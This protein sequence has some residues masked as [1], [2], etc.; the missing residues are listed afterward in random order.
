VAVEKVAA[1][2]GGEKKD[3]KK[4]KGSGKKRQGGGKKEE[5]K[6]KGSKGGD[7]SKGGARSKNSV[8]SRNNSGGKGSNNSGGSSNDS[9]NNGGKG[10]NNSGGSSSGS[11]NSG[12]KGSNNSGGSSSNDSNNSGGKGSTNSGGSSSGSNNSSIGDEEETQKGEREKGNNTSGGSSG[13]DD[14]STGDDEET[15]AELDWGKVVKKLERRERS[16]AA[17][18][19]ANPTVV[20]FDA[21]ATKT[22]VKQATT[23]PVTPARVRESDKTA[24]VN[25]AVIGP[26]TV[27]QSFTH[28]ASDK[29]VLGTSVRVS[30]VSKYATTIKNRRG[31]ISI[32]GIIGKK[33]KKN[34]ENDGSRWERKLGRWEEVG[35]SSV[36]GVE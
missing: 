13:S 26:N 9:N 28:V 17:T 20:V 25:P 30:A 23:A 3:D 18:V 24:D 33:K 35:T 8:E 7:E 2:K 21:A 36:S 4:S 19:V 1:E 27:A 22:E 31:I 29:C 32:I 11:N 10:S 34:A 12:G 16:V 15:K 14:S 5:K 6:S